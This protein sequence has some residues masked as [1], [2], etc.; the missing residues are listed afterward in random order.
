MQKLIL[1]IFCVSMSFMKAQHTDLKG[2]TF[3]A[4]KVLY[5]DNGSVKSEET[6]QMFNFSFKD[7]IMA[8]NI[9]N[10][11]IE[12]QIYKLQ[13]LSKSFDEATRKTTFRVEAVSGLSGNVY[14]YEINIDAEGTTELLLNGYLYS[15]DTYKLKTFLQE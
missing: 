1:V 7:M 6:F 2:F 11:G 4:K 13:N 15:G 9:L 8:H 10:S 12:S 14:K 5:S 3:N